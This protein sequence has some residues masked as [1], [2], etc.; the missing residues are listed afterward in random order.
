[1]NRYKVNLAIAA[2]GIDYAQ[3]LSMFLKSQIPWPS[4]IRTLFRILSAFNFDLDIAS[5]ECLVADVY[6]FDVKW[7]CIMVL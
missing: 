7:Y 1:M 3:V 6:R 5:P 4:A 2:I